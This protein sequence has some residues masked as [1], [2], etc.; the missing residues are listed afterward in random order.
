[1]SDTKQENVVY[2]IRRPEI[3]NGL[4]R[5]FHKKL[6]VMK[7]IYAEPT[8]RRPY[9]CNEIFVWEKGQYVLKR[10]PSTSLMMPF[11]INSELPDVKLLNTEYIFFYD[12][13][14]AFLFKCLLVK[15]MGK[16]YEAEIKKLQETFKR[17]VPDVSNHLDRF[18]DEMPELFI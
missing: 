5:T 15:E 2:A 14:M 4:K 16:R 3:S 11:K 10:C 13:D 6:E 9:R 18:R 7:C 12:V 8:S 17:N 1:M